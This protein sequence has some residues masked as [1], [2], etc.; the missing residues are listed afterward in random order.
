MKFLVRSLGWTR[1][2]EEFDRRVAA[3]RA[4]QTPELPFDPDSPAEEG[5]PSGSGAPRPSVADTARRASATPRGPGLYPMIEPDREPSRTREQNVV[6][7]Q[8]IDVPRV[9]ALL[10]DL[11]ALMPDSAVPIDFVDL[12]ETQTFAPEVLD[13]EC[14]A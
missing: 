13:G 6:F 14:S 2:R 8:R 9:R 1:W 4:E 11:E 5:P 3:V 12:G 7:F 10:A